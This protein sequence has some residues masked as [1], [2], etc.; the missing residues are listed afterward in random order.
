M[1]YC[2]KVPRFLPRLRLFHTPETIPVRIKTLVLEAKRSARW[3][4]LPFFAELVAHLRM[5]PW[6]PHVIRLH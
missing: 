5:L 6:W 3:I 2:R 4:W 1:A